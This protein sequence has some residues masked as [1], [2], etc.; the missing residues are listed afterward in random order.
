MGAHG[1][2]GASEFQP[3]DHSGRNPSFADA[4]PEQRADPG[5]KRELT[6][7]ELRKLIERVD[8]EKQGKAQERLSGQDGNR[9]SPE[10]RPTAPPFEPDFRSRWD[11]HWNSRSTDLGR[12]RSKAVNRKWGRDETYYWPSHKPVWT[13]SAFALG[14]LA[15]F[16]MAIYQ[17][18]AQWTP[19]QRYWL[20]NYLKT[21][22]AQASVFRPSNYRLL[23]V[24]DRP[25]RHRL[26][27]ETDVAP[28]EGPLP[29]QGDYSADPIGGSR[30]AG[31]ASGAG[32]KRKVQE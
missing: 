23:E 1:F 32:T 10:N 22:L 18:R 3:G 21:Q 14:V 15:F 7:E 8:R 29:Q 9:P 26:A 28:W 12:E 13:I 5:Q 24:E 16:G 25:G 6:T 31:P 2:A 20:P 11:R 19:L 4:V 17:A 27:V 30:T